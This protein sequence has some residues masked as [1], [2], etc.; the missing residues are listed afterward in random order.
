MV[1]LF[2]HSDSLAPDLAQGILN[3]FGT[4]AWIYSEK[5]LIFILL[6]GRFH[7]VEMYRIRRLSE[8]F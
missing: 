4:E 1:D 2:T 6:C 5:N 3:R 7:G 8:I